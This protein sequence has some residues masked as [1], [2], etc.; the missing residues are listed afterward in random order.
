MVVERLN[1]A[2][3]VVVVDIPAVPRLA[4]MTGLEEQVRTTLA[5]TKSTKQAL[6]MAVGR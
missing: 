1:V 2:M 3:V 5:S 6:D 4:T